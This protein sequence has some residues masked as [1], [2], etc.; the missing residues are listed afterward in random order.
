MER[1][2]LHLCAPHAVA[3]LATAIYGHEGGQSSTTSKTEA[4]DGDLGRRHSP[5]NHQVVCPRWLV[6]GGR[7]R[8]PD[9]E[10][11][12]GEDPVLDCVPLFF[13]GSFLLIS[14]DQSITFFFFRVL[15]V[16]CTHRLR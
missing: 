4:L 6:A 15:L 7:M 16:F 10:D 11:G 5:P 8:D 9:D 2:L 13:V 3:L 12:G 1:P 14:E